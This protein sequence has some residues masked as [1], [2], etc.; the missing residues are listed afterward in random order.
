[1]LS[2][3]PKLLP[4]ATPGASRISPVAFEISGSLDVAAA[5][6]SFPSADCHIKR[7][8]YEPAIACLWLH[9]KEPGID[10]QVN[11]WRLS[12]S[13][14]EVSDARS[15]GAAPAIRSVP[16]CCAMSGAQDDSLDH[17]EVSLNPD[18]IY[19]S[20]D[21]ATTKPLDDSIGGAP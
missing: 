11:L 12:A 10:R 9:F 20:S 5:S 15:I 8:R 21:F 7:C 2:D 14:R 16:E 18:A 1:M 6:D 19:P 3:Q 13:R 4:V 17:C